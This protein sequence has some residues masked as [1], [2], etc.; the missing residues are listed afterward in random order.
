MRTQHLLSVVVPL[1]L[2]SCIGCSN[3]HA[4]DPSYKIIGKIPGLP[5]SIYIFLMDQE[6][7]HMDSTYS[8]V[9]LAA[10]KIQN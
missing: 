10:F 1:I 5:D 8:I 2:L 7:K 9:A 4:D 3:E 6:T